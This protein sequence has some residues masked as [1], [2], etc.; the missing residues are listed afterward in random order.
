ML[1][2]EFRKDQASLGI[3]V[4]TPHDGLDCPPFITTRTGCADLRYANRHLELRPPGIRQDL[5]YLPTSTLKG[6]KG[7]AKLASYQIRM[8]H[9][10]QNQAVE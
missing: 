6:T 8:D 3:L 9:R 4:E 2:A 7:D 10:Q 1:F 5:H